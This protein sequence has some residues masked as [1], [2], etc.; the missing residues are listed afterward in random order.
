M[1]GWR[2]GMGVDRQ[3]IGSIKKHFANKSSAQLDEIVKSEDRSRWSEEAFEAARELLA[4]RAAGRAAQPA[5][6]QPEP[7]PPPHTDGYDLAISLFGFALRAAG[8]PMFAGL[9]SG[10]RDEVEGP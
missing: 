8:G 5:V 6:A 1:S 2:R 4:E 9:W 7:D 10:L 3:L